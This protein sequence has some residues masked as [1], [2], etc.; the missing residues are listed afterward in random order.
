MC[1]HTIVHMHIPCTKPLARGLREDGVIEGDLG[2]GLCV[3]GKYAHTSCMV[4]EHKHTITPSRPPQ[5]SSSL[6]LFFT[7]LMCRISAATGEVRS[8]A[9][10][11][12][13]APGTLPS[14]PDDGGDNTS[15]A[16][17]GQG[18]LAYQYEGYGGY[19]GYGGYEYEDGGSDTM[20]DSSPARLALGFPKS[21]DDAILDVSIDMR[22]ITLPLRN[23]DGFEQP[24]H[25]IKLSAAATVTVTNSFIEVGR[26]P[27]GTSTVCPPTKKDGKGVDILS[28]STINTHPGGERKR[29]LSTQQTHTTCTH[30]QKQ[31]RGRHTIC[32]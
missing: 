21:A 22:G 5:L 20:S 12:E 25:G 8:V 7:I 23:M 2:R 3:E 13:A 9:E 6:T 24:Y 10:S 30:V 14:A 27:W 28:K 18:E 17:G 1:L 4:G 19:G 16:D 31:K 29:R 15:P 26:F 32:A 11:N